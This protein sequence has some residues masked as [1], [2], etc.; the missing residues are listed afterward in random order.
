[1]CRATAVRNGPSRPASAG[2]A[3]RTASYRSV[4]PTLSR[5]ARARARA[6]TDGLPPALSP[7]PS[8]PAEQPADRAAPAAETSSALLRGPEGV[9]GGGGYGTADVLGG[10]YEHTG[11]K[12]GPR[13]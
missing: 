8:E 1:M 3:V 13:R 9:R 4:S 12:G 7:D 5:A 10:S 6:A 2:Y 11:G